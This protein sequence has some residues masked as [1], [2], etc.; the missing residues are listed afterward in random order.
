[1]EFCSTVL[2]IFPTVSI[3]LFGSPLHVVLSVFSV[4]WPVLDELVVFAFSCTISLTGTSPL[5]WNPL[6]FY[7]FC[8][9]LK[10]FFVDALRALYGLSQEI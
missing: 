4:P 2:L 7:F 8:V 5:E 9:L 6:C 1:V 10:V 3:G